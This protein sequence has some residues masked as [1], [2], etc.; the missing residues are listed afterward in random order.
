MLSET[1]CNVASDPRPH[2][3]E[4]QRPDVTLLQPALAFYLGAMDAVV[5]TAAFCGI[6]SPDGVS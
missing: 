6:A 4:F 2:G 1:G 3:N 5:A